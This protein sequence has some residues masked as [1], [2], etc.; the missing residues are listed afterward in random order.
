[1]IERFSGGRGRSEEGFTLI[2]LLVVI[3][4]LGILSAVVVFAVG[5]INDKGQNASCTI[6]TRTIRTAEEAN[7]GKNGTYVDAATLK[8]NGFLSD[9]PSLHTVQLTPAAGPATS[10]KVVVA[11]NDGGS[12]LTGACGNVNAEAG[13]C[14]TLAAPTPCADPTKPDNR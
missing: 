14:G 3:V 8:T 12:A 1:M 4:I 2:E 9:A 7:F 6:D 5:G 11:D 10:Y 13:T